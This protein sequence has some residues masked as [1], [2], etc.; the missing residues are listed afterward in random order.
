LINDSIF[1][2]IT[3][4][5]ITLDDF[6]NYRAITRQPIKL[7]LRNGETLLTA[8]PPASGGLLAFILNVMNGYRN[9]NAEELANS[10]NNT[11]TY[12]HRYMEALKF[13]FAKRS[14]MGDPD[15]DNVTEVCLI[16]SHSS[17]V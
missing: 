2:S 9:L 5:V 13:S 4:G 8:P 3:G 7:S 10:L 12:Y 11:V 14:L 17:L 16:S 1:K 6:A 15:Y